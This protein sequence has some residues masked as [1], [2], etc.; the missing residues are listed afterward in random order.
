MSTVHIWDTNT[1]S[2]I[3]NFSLGG[4]AKGVSALSISPC[5][6]YVA[7]VDQSNDHNMYIYN[8]Q[9]KKML[10]TLSAGSDSI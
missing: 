1:M 8:V 4:T 6:R 5:Q 10:L 3:A 9:R 2:S 7:V